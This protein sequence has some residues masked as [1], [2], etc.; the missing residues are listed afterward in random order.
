MKS[1][2]AFS[3]VFSHDSL[4]LGGSDISAYVVAF[5]SALW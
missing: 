2:A 3:L 1:V 4:T 5:S